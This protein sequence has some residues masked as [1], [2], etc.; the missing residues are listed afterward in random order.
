MARHQG[1]E[2]ALKVLFEHDLVQTE[3]DALLN[4][5][6]AKARADDKLF[7]E[8]LVRGVL[9]HR[10]EIDQ[11][12]EGAAI[13]WSVSR[14]PVVD[15]N[16]LRL[17]TYEL[18]ETPTVPIPVVI[19]EALD[20]AQVYSTEEAK[21]FINGVLSEVARRVRPA[22]DDDRVRVVAEDGDRPRH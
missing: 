9:A 5:A 3:I 4:R 10:T 18:T 19:D 17:A 8:E 6:L 1:R 7:A 13:D 14:M 22:G 16:I 21:R 12:I 15:R 11:A 2:F 20:L